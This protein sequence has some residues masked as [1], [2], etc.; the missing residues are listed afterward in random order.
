[1]APNANV[2]IKSESDY[3]FTGSVCFAELSDVL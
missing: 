2:A 3:N 1:M